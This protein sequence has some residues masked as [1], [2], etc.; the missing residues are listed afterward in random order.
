MIAVIA[1]LAT[2]WL[3]NA[4]LVGRAYLRTERARRAAVADRLRAH[5]E[6]ARVLGAVADGRLR[7][8]REAGGYV[9]TEMVSQPGAAVR[10]EARRHWPPQRLDCGNLF[11]GLRA[12][13][14]GGRT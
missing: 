5:A 1:I 2:A 10:A 13:T 11:K 8:E 4:A 14:G 3:L 12:N 9:L 6:L 7:V